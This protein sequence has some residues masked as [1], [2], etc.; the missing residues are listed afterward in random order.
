MN[1]SSWG[2]LKAVK[3]FLE[4]ANVRRCNRVFEPEGLLAV[5][6]LSK[7]TMKESVLDI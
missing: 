4:E 1:P 7:M 6:G 2:L 3:R 5:D